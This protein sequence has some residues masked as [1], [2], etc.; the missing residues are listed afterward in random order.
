MKSFILLIAALTAM[1]AQAGTISLD[2]RTDFDS[3]TYN[4][5]AVTAGA[6]VSN[7]RFYIPTGRIDYKGSLDADTSFRFRGRFNRDANVVENRDSLN[8]TIDYVYVMHKFSDYFGLT[9]GKFLG[10]GNGNEGPTPAGEQYHYSESFVQSTLGKYK[11]VALKSNTNT[12]TYVTGA[13]ASYFINDTNTVNFMVLDLDA[14]TGRGATTGSP[15]ANA[16]DVNSKTAAQNKSMLGVSYQGY[17]LDKN[18]SILAS[19]HTQTINSDVNANYAAIGLGYTMGSVLVTADYSA[20][21]FNSNDLGLYT[22]KDQLNSAILKVVYT[23]DPNYSVQAK[24]ISSQEKFDT[25]VAFPTGATNNYLDYSAAIEWKPK[26]TDIFRY[27]AAYVSKTETPDAGDTR[28]SSEII[29]GMR[30]LADFIK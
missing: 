13:K 8:T 30:I 20:N 12:T 11:S 19:Y 1:H 10:D 16:Q 9:A 26:A 5:A 15:A 21:T 25:S 18:F 2:L 3:T 14:D 29:V 23:I 27:H 7:Y 28:T 6:G 4:D 22:P 24:V 17:L